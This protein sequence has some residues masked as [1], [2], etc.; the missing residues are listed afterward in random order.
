M[1][2][3]WGIGQLLFLCLSIICLILRNGMANEYLIMSFEMAILNKLES[4][5]E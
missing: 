1:K 2:K 3:V 5:G 4:E